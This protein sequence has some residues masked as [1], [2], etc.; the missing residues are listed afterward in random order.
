[1]PEEIVLKC[2][3]DSGERG[4]RYFISTETGG[5][6]EVILCEN[7]SAPLRKILELSRPV[8]NRRPGGDSSKTG[9]SQAR[10]RAIFDDGQGARSRATRPKT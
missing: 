9:T 2:D 10:L 1:M 6:R 5:S 3:V 8:R 4:I 7:H